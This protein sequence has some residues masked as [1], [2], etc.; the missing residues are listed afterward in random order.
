MIAQMI[1]DGVRQ[2]YNIRLSDCLRIKYYLLQVLEYVAALCNYRALGCPIVKQ[3]YFQVNII[4][5]YYYISIVF[6]YC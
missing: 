4:I 6:Y 3:K 5:Y 1:L 2:Q